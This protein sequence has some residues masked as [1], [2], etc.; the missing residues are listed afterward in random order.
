MDALEQATAFHDEISR[1]DG[2]ESIT[3]VGQ[4]TATDGRLFFYASLEEAAGERVRTATVNADAELLELQQFPVVDECL[5]CGNV[6]DEP[7]AVCPNCHFREVD[8]CPSCQRD[9]PRE[10][11]TV[12]AGDVFAC[13]RCQAQVRMRFAEPLWLANGNYNEPV[14]RLTLAR[15]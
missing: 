11:Y 8:A 4:H 5:S 7:V 3:R 1:I 13:P 10:A 9:V 14:V 12:V 2:L 15:A 6:S